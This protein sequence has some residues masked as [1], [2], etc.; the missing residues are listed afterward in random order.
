MWKTEC[1]HSKYFYKA[2]H[3]PSQGVDLKGWLMPVTMTFP[4]P[5]ETVY[6]LCIIPQPEESMISER[7]GVFSP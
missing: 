7:E 5:V 1:P 3:L 4:Q 2:D 6:M